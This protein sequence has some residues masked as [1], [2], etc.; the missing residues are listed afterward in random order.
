[1]TDQFSGAMPRPT[2]QGKG[3]LHSSAIRAQTE[4]G[5]QTQWMPRLTGFR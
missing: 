1:M 4:S 3:M 5:M 2:A